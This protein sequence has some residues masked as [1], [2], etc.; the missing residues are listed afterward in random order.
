MKWTT[1]AK[2]AVV[3]VLASVYAFGG[4]PTCTAG[5]GKV[6]DSCSECWASATSCGCIIAITK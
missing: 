3:A 5:N 2:L 6:C 4:N 1:F